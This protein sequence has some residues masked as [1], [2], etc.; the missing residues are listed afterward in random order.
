MNRIS[1]KFITTTIH[2]ILILCLPLSSDIPK[3]KSFIVMDGC[4]VRGLRLNCDRKVFRDTTVTME[5]EQ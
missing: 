2:I 1:A 4:C 3:Q 5:N